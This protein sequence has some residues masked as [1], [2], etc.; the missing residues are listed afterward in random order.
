MQTEVKTMSNIKVEALLFEEL[1]KEPSYFDAIKVIYASL[2]ENNKRAEPK[3]ICSPAI[4][5]PGMGK[6]FFAY[7]ND[8]IVGFMTCF[9]GNP[10]KYPEAIRKHLDHNLWF[11]KEMEAIGRFVFQDQIIVKHGYQKKGIGTL[12]LQKMEE[13]CQ[14][15]GITF[16][17]G[18]IP[19]KNIP[20]HQFFK[21]HGYDFIDHFVDPNTEKYW[22]R[23]IKVFRKYEF[24]RE[25]NAKTLPH[26]FK[27]LI[28]L[29]LNS[30]TKHINHLIKRMGAEITWSAFFHKDELINQHFGIPKVYMGYFDPIL[31]TNDPDK[32]EK[33]LSTLKHLLKYFKDLPKESVASLTDGLNY[34]GFEFFIVD[35]EVNTFDFKNSFVNPIIYNVHQ[36]DI[37]SL[38]KNNDLRIGRTM[39]PKE[40]IDFRR[41]LNLAANQKYFVYEKE[42]KKKWKKWKKNLRITKS[43]EQMLFQIVRQR[44]LDG[45]SNEEQETALLKEI[46]KRRLLSDR[47]VAIWEDWIQL[48]KEEQETDMMGYGEDYQWCHAVV[49]IT[50]SDGP[51]RIAFSF[52]VHNPEKDSSLVP[53]LANLISSALAK[54][55]FNIMLKLKNSV[56]EEQQLRFATSKVQI[57]NL[58]HNMGSHILAHLSNRKKLDSYLLD[59]FSDINVDQVA[60]FYAYLQTR[61]DYLADL[62]TSDPVV[63]VPR[64]INQE[65]VRNFNQELVVRQYISGTDLQ[66]GEVAFLDLEKRRKDLLVQIPNGDLGN[67]ALYNILENIIRNSAKHESLAL[68]RKLK[69]TIACMGSF[70]HERLYKFVIYDNIPRKRERTRKGE[71]T[72]V[73]KI[74]SRFINKEILEK[75]TQIRQEGW[76]LMEMKIAAAY[77]RKYPSQKTNERNMEFPLLTAVE[78][79]I[80][81]DNKKDQYYLGYEIYLK[82]PRE[83]LILDPDD[84]LITNF[85]VG[86]QYNKGIRILKKGDIDAR[87]NNKFSHTLAVS[88]KARDSRNITKRKIYPIRGITFQ[89]DK[90]KEFLQ[91]KINKSLDSFIRYAYK[92][93]IQEYHKRKGLTFNYQNLI[94]RLD[95]HEDIVLPTEFREKKIVFDHHYKLL[96]DKNFDPEDYYF[97]EG[98]NTSTPAGWL[99]SHLNKE[100]REMQKRIRMEL[101]EAALTKVVIIDERIQKEA[102]DKFVEALPYGKTFLDE[103]RWANIYVPDKNEIDLYNHKEFSE[104]KKEKTIK[105][106]EKQYSDHRPDFFVIHLGI[107]EKLVGSSPDEIESFIKGLI[108]IDDQINI[109]LTTGRG[110]PHSVPEDALFLHYSNVSKHIIQHKSK[111]HLCKVLFSARTRIK[112][113]G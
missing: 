39:N 2:R 18:V 60:R 44:N 46:T 79:E 101:M 87:H 9:W 82:K 25:I 38:T 5:H 108:R 90:E 53:E 66:C 6:V 113:N 16:V 64:K 34:K 23:I 92:K 49:P 75:G 68:V 52:R 76:G 109:V 85:T 81:D 71:E 103:L 95:G 31:G 48:H 65:L 78:V 63:A 28:P 57:R 74:N 4:L 13:C 42:P 112:T 70:N 84:Y 37:E 58:A 30:A 94:L 83:I 50:F 110:K 35:G 104:N 17:G 24:A 14:D 51:T 102:G 106:I 89:T 1:H 59:E 12:L 10:E 105:W 8:Q 98:F 20:T 100:T 107:I 62:A 69:L 36:L 43:E 41:I 33:T 80:P 93:W 77:L 47:E 29:Q 111:Y 91:R 21:K 56:I 86:Q 99:F 7:E 55:M 15:E 3:K 97:Y 19:E 88:I 67:H 32:F 22:C 61:M 26:A 54:N 11:A 45:V 27:T 73:Q 40:K 96:K 72:L